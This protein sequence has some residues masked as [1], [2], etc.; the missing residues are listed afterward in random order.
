MQN[1]TIPKQANFLSLNPAIPPL[2]Q[3]RMI[4]PKQTQ[5]WN[6]YRRIAVINNYGAADSNVAIVLLEKPPVEAEVV[7][8]MMT[9]SPDDLP[10]FPILVSARTPESLRSYC[11]TLKSYIARSQDADAN[12]MLV[13]FAFNLATKHN[14]SF[15]YIWTS[16]SRDFKTLFDKS[17]ASAVE[18]KAFIRSTDVKRPVILCFGGQT[19]RVVSLSKDLFDNCRLLRLHMVGPQISL[20]CNLTLPPE[21]LR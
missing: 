11:T 15:E 6:V 8:P 13:N 5:P 18:P 10:E 17:E 4:I 20:S 16:T 14:R 19:G 12:N 9:L 3:D 2:K 7:V 1:R 21:H